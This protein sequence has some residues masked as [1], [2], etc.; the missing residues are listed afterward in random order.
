M[1][2]FQYR[3][4][5]AAI[6]S[7]FAIVVVSILVLIASVTVLPMYDNYRDHGSIFLKATPERRNV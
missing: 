6:Y 2:D 1:S 3:V 4:A 7:L 5:L